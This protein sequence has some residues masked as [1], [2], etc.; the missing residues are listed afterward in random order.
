M[1]LLDTHIW[2]WWV[3]DTSKLTHSQAALLQEEEQTGGLGVSAISLWEVAK[4]VELGKLSLPLPVENW[5]S[6]Y[7][8]TLENTLRRQSD[9]F[10]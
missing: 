7:S 3:Q 6:Q 10:A 1:I 9:F 4:L 5:L 2:I 8:L